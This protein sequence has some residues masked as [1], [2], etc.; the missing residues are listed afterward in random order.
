HSTHIKSRH[1]HHRPRTFDIAL[2]HAPRR[3]HARPHRILRPICFFGRRSSLH[4][5]VLHSS[6]QLRTL[7]RHSPSFFIGIGTSAPRVDPL[8]SALRWPAVQHLHC[9]LSRSSFAGHRIVQ[10]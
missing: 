2:H 9:R 6:L 5:H 7:H 3:H 10:H 8:S 4:R 1:S